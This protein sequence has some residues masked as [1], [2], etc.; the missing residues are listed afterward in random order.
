MPDRYH[1]KSLPAIGAVVLFGFGLLLAEAQ[2]DPLQLR[3]IREVVVS[4]RYSQALRAVDR[5]LLQHPDDADL[6]A[7]RAQVAALI[8]DPAGKP[9]PPGTIALPAIA[10]QE[11][12]PGHSFTV[13]AAGIALLWVEPGSFLMSN[14]QGSDDDTLVTLSRGY[15]LGRTEVTQEQW[16]TL[17]EN[18]PMPSRFK[19]SERPVE[20]VSWVSVMEFCRKLTERERAAGRLPTGYEYTLPTEAQWEYACRAGTTGPFA[21]AIDELAWYK[22]NSGGQTHPVGQKQ[23]NA[24]G[25]Y[26]MH[27]NVFEWCADGYSGYPGGEAVDPMTDYTGPSAATMRVHRGGGWGNT[28]GQCRSSNRYWAG[29]NYNGPGIGFRLALAP[30]RADSVSTSSAPSH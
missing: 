7:L 28:V 24:W 11:A 15:W 29:L 3:G 30:I 26:D 22:L 10:S 14:P 17:M 8:V 19:G 9:A 18:I 6:I 2:V 13:P 20:C 12:N 25:F 27:G 4:G 5:L 1:V 16:Q 21:G 23:P